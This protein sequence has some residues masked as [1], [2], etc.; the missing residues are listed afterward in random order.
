[1]IALWFLKNLTLYSTKIFIIMYWVKEIYKKLPP[2]FFWP[3][4]SHKHPDFEY[5]TRERT[6]RRKMV[7]KDEKKNNQLPVLKLILNTS[8]EY[9]HLYIFFFIDALPGE[10]KICLYLI[11][12]CNWSFDFWRLFLYWDL[13]LCMA[14]YWWREL[15]DYQSLPPSAR[16][17]NSFHN[18]RWDYL[19]R[20]SYSQY[21]NKKNVLKLDEKTF[22]PWYQSIVRYRMYKSH[23]RVSRWN[24]WLDLLTFPN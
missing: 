15:C 3:C 5:M 18:E 16:I 2:F 6:E 13:S 22:L 21:K 17:K 4:I 10:N 20:K 19:Q 23:T 7:R 11:K 14:D 12:H 8:N 24:G 9:I 1:M